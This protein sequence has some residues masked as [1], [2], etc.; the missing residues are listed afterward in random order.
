MFNVMRGP[1]IRIGTY[2]CKGEC[3]KLDLYYS[4]LPLV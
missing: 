1:T 3:A 2:P 4:R